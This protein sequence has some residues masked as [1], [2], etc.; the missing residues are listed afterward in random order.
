MFTWRDSIVMVSGLSTSNTK[1]FSVISLLIFQL[2]HPRSC[3]SVHVRADLFI[4]DQVFSAQQVKSWSWLIVSVNGISFFLIKCH[5]YAPA[6][7][8]FSRRSASTPIA[9]KTVV[10]TLSQFPYIVTSYF[11]PLPRC[12]HRAVE[13]RGR[14]AGTGMRE[15]VEGAAHR[16]KWVGVIVGRK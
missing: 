2:R 3:Q 10:T 14:I 9:P 7:L 5:P 16:V 6:L 8:R 11:I 4:N 13:A 12:C 15:D 1:S